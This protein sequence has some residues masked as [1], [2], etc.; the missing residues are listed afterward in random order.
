M[1]FL[2]NRFLVLVGKLSYGIYLYHILYF[3]VAVELWS[4]YVYP[5]I[6]HIYPGYQTAIFL[7][8]NFWILLGLWWLSWKFIESPIL[9]LKS[10]FR[11][12]GKRDDAPVVPAAETI[13]VHPT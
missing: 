10:K 1:S 13:V 11:Y 5:R 12:Q 4:K 2:G 8:L 6:M 9:R 3:Y 7:F